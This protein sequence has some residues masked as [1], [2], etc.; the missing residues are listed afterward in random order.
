MMSLKALLKPTCPWGDGYY[1]PFIISKG[2]YITYQLMDHMRFFQGLKWI[3]GDVNLTRRRSFA[4]FTF[5]CLV[6]SAVAWH[7]YYTAPQVKEGQLGY[8]NKKALKKQATIKGVMAFTFAHVGEVVPAYGQ[9]SFFYCC[10]SFVLLGICDTRLVDSPQ[11]NE[12][13]LVHTLLLVHT[14]AHHHR[15]RT[16]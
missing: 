9:C 11:H 8:V 3:S 16:L 2:T 13:R 5:S 15:P 10:A 6:E 4:L 1:L 7:R 14:S 12:L